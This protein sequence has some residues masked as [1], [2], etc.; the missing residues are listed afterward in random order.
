MNIPKPEELDSPKKKGTLYIKKHYPEFHQY[1]LDN[2]PHINKFNAGIYLYFHHMDHPVCPICGKPVPFLDET[3]GFQRCCSSKCANSDPDFRKRVQ[4]TCLKKYGAKTPAESMQVKNKLISTYTARHGGMG[5]AS[6]NVQRK[7]QTTMVSLYGVK[8]ALKSEQIKSTAIATHKK[9]YGGIG[10]S[11]NNRAKIERT[12]QIRYG[13]KSPLSSICVQTKLK[14]TN[15]KLYGSEYAT[16]NPEIAQKI[17]DKKT[18]SFISYHDDIISIERIADKIIYTCQCPHPECEQCTQKT[19]TIQA[20][21]YCN[22]RINGTE[23]CTN[24]VPVLK[25]RNKGTYPEI[26][27]RAILNDIIEPG[28]LRYNCKSLIAPKEVD[29][30]DPIAR[31][32]IECN[33]CYWH[34]DKN[35]SPSYHRNKYIQCQ[36]HGVQLLTIWE[37]W[38]KTKPEIV[39]S[40]I[41]A[42]Y[43]YFQ[44]SIYGRKCEISAVPAVDAHTFLETNHIQGGTRAHIHYGLYHCGELVSLMSFS[45]MRG[46]M[47]SQSS[48]E[49]QW[50][51]VRFCNKLNTQ[52]I[53]AADKLMKHF[54][55]EFHPNTIISFSSNDISNG[56][57]YKRLGF[58]CGSINQSYWY[59]GPEYKRYHRSNFTKNAIIKKGMAPDMDT[60]TETDA[61]LLHGFVKIYDSGQTKWVLKIEGS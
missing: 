56:A 22:R 60:W 33:G 58:E 7:Q 37:D 1:I 51:L 17:S 53:G 4:E 3:R 32:A 14:E 13:C 35:K 38:I 30:Y 46:C 28:R 41:R 16:Q 55:K 49:G 10:M 8:H 25:S 45:K 40:I 43:H 44:Q 19:Y 57:L 54:I 39:K 2:Y 48:R 11:G 23:P 50:E 26:F 31:I 9:R 36:K 18:K 59:I 6:K 34:S 24:L 47:G 12:N 20:E 5:N 21:R 42:K 61:M 52:V 29:I 27:I 15:L